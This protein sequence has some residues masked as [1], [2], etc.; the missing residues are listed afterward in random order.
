MRNDYRTMCTTTDDRGDYRRHESQRALIGKRGYMRSAV[1]IDD[2]PRGHSSSYLVPLSTGRAEV[3]ADSRLPD[4]NSRH[5]NRDTIPKRYRENQTGPARSDGVISAIVPCLGCCP[6]TTHTCPTR[7]HRFRTRRL[8]VF[9]RD[10]RPPTPHPWANG[11]PTDRNGPASSWGT[12]F[13][14]LGPNRFRQVTLDPD[15]VAALPKYQSACPARGRILRRHTNWLLRWDAEE[16]DSY[17]C[18][19]FGG[20]ALSLASATL[21]LLPSSLPVWTGPIKK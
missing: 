6:H 3:P 19:P 7:T 17:G 13:P 11:N 2:Q 16:W 10:M 14:D 21:L 18:E 15:K 9:L 8:C 1:R 5:T 4:L 12:H 20:L